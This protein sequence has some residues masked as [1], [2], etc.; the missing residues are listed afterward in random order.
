[1]AFL[2]VCPQKR[3]PFS[4]SGENQKEP[5]RNWSPLQNTHPSHRLGPGLSRVLMPWRSPPCRHCWTDLRSVGGSV[6][7]G[8]G[9]SGRGLPYRFEEINLG[10]SFW[11]LAKNVE[12]GSRVAPQINQKEFQDM[13][14]PRVPSS[15]L[16]SCQVIWLAKP[17][18]R[19]PPLG[20]LATRTKVA[21]L[22]QPSE[23]GPPAI[24]NLLD[25]FPHVRTKAQ[26]NL[27]SKDQPPTTLWRARAW[28]ILNIPADAWIDSA[29]DNWVRLGTLGSA[30][31]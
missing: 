13:A 4:G 18:S 6:W 20:G 15:S 24:A 30:I 7:C 14:F 11:D 3:G 17:F 10:A 22:S 9:S 8:R 29:W 2:C 12:D 21:R 16:E 27:G 19:W 28:M 1:M 23:S 31:S 25:S 26:Q 5:W